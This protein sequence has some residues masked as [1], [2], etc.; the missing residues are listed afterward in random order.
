MSTDGRPWGSRASDS[1]FFGSAAQ[2]KLLQHDLELS[3][4]EALSQVLEQGTFMSRCSWYSNHCE[5]AKSKTLLSK[6]SQ[7]HLGQEKLMA[8]SWQHRWVVQEQI[9]WKSIQSW[10]WLDSQK[11]PDLVNQCKPSN[12]MIVMDCD[13]FWPVYWDGRR[14]TSDTHPPAP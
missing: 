7:M 8:N 13:Q 5:S 14:D 9:H 11:I 4:L 1:A 10:K 12:C 2:K 3:A 6:Q